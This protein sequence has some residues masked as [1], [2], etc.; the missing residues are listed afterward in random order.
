M[1]SEQVDGTVYGSVKVTQ[2]TS[3]EPKTKQRS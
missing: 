2:N 3:V 1:K